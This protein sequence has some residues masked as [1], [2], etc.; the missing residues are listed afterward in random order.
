MRIL[1]IAILTLLAFGAFAQEARFVSAALSPL[2]RAGF[3]A[4]NETRFSGHAIVTETFKVLWEPGSEGYPGYFRILLLPNLASRRT[5]PHDVDRGPV[6]ELWLRNTEA[7]LAAFASPAQKEALKRTPT[8]VLTGQVTVEITSY[9]TGVDCDQR[10]YNATLV[11]G[12]Q[13]PIN[14]VA[15][16]QTESMDGC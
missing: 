14:V 6:R 4:P 2:K 8:T 10:G 11:A 3:V 16:T 5:L 9:Q 13:Q 15:S 1:F 7:A 12:V